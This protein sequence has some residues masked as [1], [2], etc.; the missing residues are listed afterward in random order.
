MGPPCPIASDSSGSLG[1]RSHKL[2][3]TWGVLC[4][5]YFLEKMLIQGALLLAGGTGWYWLLQRNLGGVLM[6]VFK[7]TDA[8][9]VGWKA[10]KRPSCS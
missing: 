3:V 7:F 5:L 6:S 1:H 2:R 8:V 10:A 4:R 9:R